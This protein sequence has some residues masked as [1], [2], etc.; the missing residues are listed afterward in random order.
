MKRLSRVTVA[1][2][3]AVLLI[4]VG[5]SAAGAHGGAAAYVLVSADFILPGQP[6]EVM[7][8]DIGEDAPVDFSIV[9]G[10]RNEVLGT[11]RAAPDGHLMADLVVPADFPTGYAQLVATVPNVAST[12]TWVYVG[13]R[14]A[15]TP[16]PPAA[17][18]AAPWWSDPSVI[19]LGLLMLGVV[20]AVGYLVLRSRRAV[21]QPAVAATA[22]RRSSGKRSRR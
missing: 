11:S 8:A 4:T 15:E 18:S 7:V 2:V 9:Q 21:P 14:T 20:G 16:P 19:V 5:A 13:E 10:E 12:S 1:L 3:S 17:A 6:F 22:P